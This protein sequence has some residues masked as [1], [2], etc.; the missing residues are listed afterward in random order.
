MASHFGVWSLSEQEVQG[1]T[2]PRGRAIAVLFPS[3][4][5]VHKDAHLGYLTSILGGTGVLN[6]FSTYKGL[7]DIIVLSLETS[8]YP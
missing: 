1:K 3:Q 2:F 7:W 4:T 5:E 8:M 6:V